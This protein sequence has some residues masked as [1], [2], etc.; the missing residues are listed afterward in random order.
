ML[1]RSQV[2]TLI[3]IRNQGD[4]IFSAL[5]REL[6]HYLFLSG[7]HDLS[8]DKDTDIAILLKHIVFGSYD[9]AE[10]MLE[11]NPWLLLQY[12]HIKA[13]S[14]A[15]IPKTTPLQC[16]FK[17]GDY[18]MAVMICLFFN[19]LKNGHVLYAEE[20]AKCKKHFE[21]MTVLKEFLELAY[22]PNDDMKGTIL[23]D[24]KKYDI[25]QQEDL[26]DLF[27]ILESIKNSSPKEVTAALNFTIEHC[28][29]LNQALELFRR[30]SS[31]TALFPMHS[32]YRKLIAAIFIY[33]VY[34]DELK[35]ENIDKCDLFWR[36]V[37]GYLQR[38]LFAVELQ[39]LEGSAKTAI[40]N[41]DAPAR[42]IV[43]SIKHDS[44]KGLGYEYALRFDCPTGSKHFHEGHSTFFY[45]LKEFIIMKN[46]K[47]ISLDPGH[48]MNVS[49]KMNK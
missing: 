4:S 38:G 20:Y 37:V 36:Q 14:G 1:D 33:I 29:P 46:L 24:P 21:D 7:Y 11:E 22:I 3:K 18:H 47:L 30:R 16:A 45:Q 5:P 26:K 6:A 9:A 35:R 19:R 27:K 15:I 32:K 49:P 2:L 42:P 39:A 8:Y 17:A 28:N 25:T 12:S 23:P 13:P 10:D 44:R 48:V 34:F 41:M 31:P 40:E 43:Q